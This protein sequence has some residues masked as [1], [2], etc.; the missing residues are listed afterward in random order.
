MTSVVRSAALSLAYEGG[1]AYATVERISARTKIA[2]TTIYRRW[3]NAGAIVADALFAE[4]EIG[5]PRTLTGPVDQIF[6]ELT[7]QFTESISA[8]QIILL[9]SLIAEAQR[10][11]DFRKAFWAEC[12]EPSRDYARKLLEDAVLSGELHSDVDPEIVLD[13]FCGAMYYRLMCRER[14]RIDAEFVDKMIHQ[15]FSGIAVRPRTTRSTN[16]A[17]D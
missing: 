1:F 3:P 6:R 16:K 10:N 11:D 15:L 4:I 8:Q 14:P 2:K 17:T 9:G 7:L 12:I 5:V 13:T